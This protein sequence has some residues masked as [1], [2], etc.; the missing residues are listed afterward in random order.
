VATELGRRAIGYEIDLELLDII[1]KK[2]GIDQKKLLGQDFEI[3]IRDDARNLRT[4]LQERVKK[5]R[6]V[7]QR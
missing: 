2:L 4:W 1:K 7:V 5:Q 3:I 6:S